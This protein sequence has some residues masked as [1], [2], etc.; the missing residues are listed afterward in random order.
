MSTCII[1]PYNQI[2]ILK[3]QFRHNDLT[4]FQQGMESVS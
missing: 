3:G 2:V 1:L 4:H